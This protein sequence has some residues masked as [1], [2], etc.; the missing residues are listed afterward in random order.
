MALGD[1]DKALDLAAGGQATLILSVESAA[2]FHPATPEQVVNACYEAGF[3]T[4]HR[5]VLGDELV[6]REYL[7]LWAEPGWGT[8][9]RST[10]PVIV[11]Q[12][13]S[14]HPELIPYLAPVD[15]PIAAEA[16]YL[17]AMYG[18]NLKVVYAGVC[19][20]EG[21][22]AVDAAIT[23]A[24]LAKLLEER[25]VRVETQPPHFERMPEERRRHWSTAGGMPLEI[26]AEETHA[27]RRFKKVRGLSQLEAMARAVSVDR[28]DLGFVDILP[29]EGCLDHPLL[30]PKEELFWR[31]AVVEASEP[32]RSKLP[33]LDPEVM[34]R[35]NVGATFPVDARTSA[36]VPEDVDEILSEIGMA[37]NG[38]AWDCGACGYRTCREFAGAMIKGRTTYK[39][40]PPYLEKQTRAAQQ[41]AAVDGL[42]GLATFRVLRDRLGNEVARTKRSGESFAVLFV[43]LDH[44]KQVNDQFGHEA[45]NE[46]LRGAAREVTAAIRTADFAA[47]Y[48]GDEF[49]VILVRTGLSGAVGVAEKLRER[50]VALGTELG[51]PKGFIGASIGVAEYRLEGAEHEDVLVAA[52]R[53]LY[54]AKAGGRNQVA[55]GA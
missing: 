27:S 21:G 48:G 6:A 41:Q 42:T 18:K 36:V 14:E 30:G 19:L 32:P 47:R 8:M 55:T 40:C 31:R 54:R 17:K 50:V 10:C 46:V 28:I 43:D 39:S 22:D 29:C 38:R 44:F 24:D 23:F 53:A 12:I 5:G 3:R 20:T 52:D 34:G 25:E 16:K 2:F 15:T 51:Y 45:G 1:Y 7:R 9:I 4:V 49:V 13:R 33:V 37:P 11:E 35:V 26:L